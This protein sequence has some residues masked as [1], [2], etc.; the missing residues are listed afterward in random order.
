MQAKSL[1]VQCAASERTNEMTRGLA[2]DA[3]TYAYALPGSR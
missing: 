1:E 3:A 2:K